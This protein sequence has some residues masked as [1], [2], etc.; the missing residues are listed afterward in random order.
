MKNGEKESKRV[1]REK[2][3]EKCGGKGDEIG[4]KNVSEDS[5]NPFTDCCQ[6]SISLPESEFLKAT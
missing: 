5:E 1:R 4:K 6:Q 3:E 2:T